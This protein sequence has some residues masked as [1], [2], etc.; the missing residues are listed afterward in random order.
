MSSDETFN[1]LHWQ[2]DL[3]GSIEVGLA[4]LDKQFNVLVWNQFM[5]NHSGI[6]PSQIRGKC[7]FDFFK[8][9]DRDWFQRKAEPVFNLRSS[10]FM[11]WEQRPYLFKFESNRP[12]TSASEHMFQNVTV[13]PLT[14]LNDQ[15]EQICL[16][17]YDVTDEA[18][19]KLQIQ[20]LNETLENMSRVD[21]LT[22]LYNRRFW[23]EQFNL[24]YKRSKR[25]GH[26]ASLI[27]L[28]IDHFKRVNDTYGHPGGDDVIK[29]LARIIK[30]SVRETD[31]CGRYGGEEFAILLP[32]T[33]AKQ[34]RIVAERI[35]KLAE[36]VPVEHEE[37]TIV[38]T[39]SLGIAELQDSY[40]QPL[41]WLEKAD[42]A[43]YEAKES[44][45]NRVCISPS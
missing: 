2:H 11:I 4:V 23:E 34:A 43:L 26:P 16:V 13:F 14:S 6:L 30:K 10:A 44:G 33:T 27:M 7:L 41:V 1:E 24:E 18:L 19:G 25:A 42:Q 17:V 5:E 15:V 3:L 39:V 9:I 22:G 38:F 29:M 35:R 37:H 32:D 36:H 45:R 28:D 8:E 12:I 31:V 20:R 40:Q 21:G